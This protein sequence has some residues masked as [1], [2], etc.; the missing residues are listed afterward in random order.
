MLRR[1]RLAAPGCGYSVR[2]V[3]IMIGEGRLVRNAGLRRKDGYGPG[4]SG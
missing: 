1:G 2:E 3:A 4:M